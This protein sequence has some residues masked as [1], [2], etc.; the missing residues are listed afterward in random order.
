M[1]KLILIVCAFI[2]GNST[3]SQA[4]YNT[5]QQEM[6]NAYSAHPSV[7]RGVLEGWSFAMT[8]FSH[9]DENIPASCFGLPR[10]YGVMGLTEDGQ[11]YF[12]NN[13]I[14]VSNLSG[15]SVQEIKN[16]PQKNILAFASAYEHL[17]QQ[18]GITST[19]PKDHLLVL[20]ALCEIPYD[21]HP[22]NNFALNSHIYSV[23][24]FL[25]KQS[26]QTAYNIP[27]YN[28]D[29][30]DV[31][32]QNLDILSA[33]S[34]SIDTSISTSTGATYVPMNLKSP[35]YP[36]ALWTATPTCNYS[37]RSGTAVSAM[38]IHTIQGTYAGA[39]SWA[40]NCSANVSYH[41]VVRSSDGQVTQMV[42]EADKAWHVGS[43]NP[44]T[45][46]IEH[47]GYV[48]D[49]SWYTTALYEASANI[50]KDVVNSGYG[51]DPL[52]TYYG[53][54]SSGTNTIGGCTK[55][56]GHQ[57]YPN[58]TH[59]D[60]GINWDWP[61][62]YK[63]INDN[64]NITTQTSASGSLFDSGGSTGNYTDDER[65]LWLIQPTGA[66]NVT[67]TF[68]SFDIEANWDYMFIY[69]GTTTDDPLLGTFTGT[70]NP[71][72][73]SSTGG[74]LLIEFRSDCAT[75]SSGWEIVWNSST[76]GGG[77]D[78][79]APTTTVSSPNNWKT[80][81][82]TATFTDADNTGG[83]GVDKVFYQVI[84]YDGSDWRA[85]ENNGF[86]SDNFDQA[87]IHSDWTS[88]VGTWSL[89]NGFLDQ[90]DETEGNTNIYASLDQNNDDE[91][92]YHFAINIDGSGTYN[93]R[94]G[95]HFMC[96]D[97]SQTE[98]GNSYFVW[99]RTDDN[100][101]QIY[102][103]TNNVFSLQVDEPFTLNNDQ[104]YDAKITYDKASGEIS[105][106]VDNVYVTSWTDATP[107]TTGNAISFRSGNSYISANNIK[108][109]H[110]RTTSETVTVGTTGDI[111]YQNTAPTIPS[112]KVKSI[113]I[114]VA[115]N[116]S[117][118]SS[119]DINVDWTV[120]SQVTSLNDGTSTDIDNQTDNTQLS[121]NW[122]ASLDQHSDIARYWYAIGSTSGGTDIVGWTDNWF[123]TSFTH[124]GL[125]LTYGDTYYV[126]VKTE[127]GAGLICSPINS[128]GVTID[129]PSNPPVAAFNM[130]NTSVCL[131]QSLALTNSS[132]DA[133]SY[134]WTTTGGTLSS[135]TAANP[136]ISFSSSGSYTISLTATGPG[137]TDNTSQTFNVT[138]EQPPV[139]NASVSNTN[140]QA[141]DPVTFTNGSTN[142]NG[143]FWNFGDGSTS[144]ATDPTHTYS[145]SGTYDVMLIAINGTC[146][147]D[148]TYFTINVVNPAN[149]PVAG[150]SASNTT[151][152]SGG[153]IQLSNSSTDATSYSWTTS[154]GTLS[155]A[156]AANPSVSFTTSGSY[157]VSLTATGPGGTDNTS[158]TI[159]VN[160]V[161]PPTAG[162]TASN[163]TPSVNDLITFTNTSS[164][165]TSY[166]WYFG[167]GNT[168]ISTNPTNTYTSSGIYTVTLIAG[169]GSCANDTTYLSINVVNAANPPVAGFNTNGTHVCSTEPVQLNNTSV[170]ANS[171]L[172]SVTGGVLSS[173]TDTNPTVL[174]STS[175]TYNVTLIATGPGGTDNISQ[176]ITVT[177]ED[178]P[179]ANGSLTNAPLYVNDVAYFSN[180]STNGI[181]Y[182]WDFGDGSTSTDVNPWHIYTVAGTYTVEVTASN[183]YCPSDA[184]TFVVEVLDNSSITEINGLDQLSVYPNPNDGNFNIQIESSISL[185][186][187]FEIFD[188]TGKLIFGSREVLPSGLSVIPMS[189]LNNLSSGIYS[190]NI[191]N[192]DQIVTKKLIIK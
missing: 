189:G 144:S 33:S 90:S 92:L 169:N 10:T 102:E 185:V 64:P 49:P 46:G 132:S 117:S 166:Y 44:Y 16:D 119:Q 94:A 149:P 168:S 9:L 183:N 124:T 38:T 77:S 134:A 154:G 137:G 43:E 83:S 187:R 184:N 51:L 81:D 156:T 53:A 36:A 87:S 182:I 106:W 86:F 67:I 162:A 155:S 37:S 84:D 181:S 58:Q 164:N 157:T 192:N 82:F 121:A 161:Q 125:S 69:D 112:G 35:D 56:K 50:C 131:G 6:D 70:T 95:F 101:V 48:S 186:L 98:R 129:N 91:W 105:V 8:H 93:R 139:A 45:I 66:S 151:V 173:N 138:V 150:F 103:T 99:F 71:G 158:Q 19:N 57:H 75:T 27:N 123:N 145:A 191:S 4:I 111:R 140:P 147:N 28:I 74:A 55:I 110:N 126:S 127:N 172:W 61:R 63:L 65:Y 163:T 160:V 80:T 23:L 18:F 11:G 52:R 12:R 14:E 21:H 7:P 29:L 114:D 2:L 41:Y 128:D 26:N 59:T 136:S 89:V 85:N 159:S 122:G 79:T 180:S 32:G 146:D 133:T 3:F 15:Y 148:T 88:S 130:F 78:V 72:T 39:I 20:Q 24:S 34:I 175:G 96:D 118:I 31:F 178:P 107:L 135:S 30:F 62:Y 190:L 5:Y 167:D 100:K 170:D 177:V 142:A 179:L 141:N 47:D 120:P 25:N 60:P 1:K 143:Y 109:Y 17:L 176:N 171:F 165:A 97:A 73:I 188:V 174:F 153:S 42:L 40:Q 68:N 22:A 152:C 108:V 104:W 115:K 13:M 113:I 116:I 54:S 76:S